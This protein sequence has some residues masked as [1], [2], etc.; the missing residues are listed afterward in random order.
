MLS[1]CLLSHLR[2]SVSEPIRNF[3]THQTK[4][5]RQTLFCFLGWI[6]TSFLIYS[7]KNT[8]LF[9]GKITLFTKQI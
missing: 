2:T 9:L 8:Q 5:L 6:T 1:Q 4:P 3:I 7:P